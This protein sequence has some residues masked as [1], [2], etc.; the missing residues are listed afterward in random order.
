MIVSVDVGG[1]FSDFV[2]LEEG[3]IKAYKR[4]NPRN[5]AEGIIKEIK[6]AEE[7]HHGTT[8]AINALLE[9]KGKK[10]TLITTKGFGTL[11][12]IGRQNRMN[13]YSL[14]PKREI[15]PVENVIE[16]EERTLPDGSIEKEL[17]EKELEEKLSKMKCESAAVVFLHSY[18]NPHNE[19]RAK[20]IAKKFC[21]YVFPSHEVRRE[22]R[23][24]ER[25]STTIV[26][27]YIYPVV[28]EYL[29]SLRYPGNKF[30]VMQSSG[31]KIM[32]EH[33][34]GVNTL[35]SGPS[36]GVAAARYLSQLLGFK[37]IITYDMGGTSADMGIIVNG[38]TLY[39]SQ[40]EVDGIPIRVNSVDIVSIGAGGG[41]IAWID[42]GNALRVG[43]MSA[44][45]NPG[46]ACYGRGGKDATVTDANLLLG[47]LGDEISGV[48]LNRELAKRAMDF[49]ADKLGMLVEESTRGIV[50][51][52][53]NNMALAMKK[54]SLE[55][56]YDSRNFVLFAFGGAGP[57][58]AVYLAEELGISKIFVPSMAGVFSS[59]GILL[60]PLI[61][62]HTVTVMKGVDEFGEV[63]DGILQEF[64]KRADDILKNYQL[65][66]ILDMRYRGQGHEIKVP[67]CENIAREFEN[68]HHALYGFTMDEE[69]VVVNV[70]LIA[71]RS[72]EINIP[73]IKIGQ[74]KI[75]GER[76]YNF[77]TRVPI[78]H[79]NH[80]KSCEGPCIV[81]EDTATILIKEGWCAE[82]KE[83]GVIM[84]ACG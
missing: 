54:I 58:H 14:L 80:F 77:D 59:L 4:I 10:V 79:I 60:S 25:T 19:M 32:P 5:V 16:V 74:Q 23:E 71:T 27:S 30:Y 33:L 29:S 52:V 65:S 56:G 39:R 34:K 37:N 24:Y 72:K 84:E 73:K 28:S 1:T 40:I 66:V 64:K 78:Y 36:G 46:P 83:Y 61:Y 76:I 67:L 70:N 55:R 26:E 49:L 2:V 35:M 7:F 20:E 22:I 42:E 47:V 50:D 57:M 82:V 63:F 41:S 45:A 12:R 38:E 18:A 13:V 11:Y 81:E 3:R 48:R 69:I 51:I 21:K 75:K 44:G 8:I 53:N 9:R 31:G 43:P 15:L 6:N 68:R 62:D 17:N